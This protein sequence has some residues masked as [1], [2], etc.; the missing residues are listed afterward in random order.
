MRVLNVFTGHLFSRRDEKVRE[1]KVYNVVV[2]AYCKAKKPEPLL[3]I[4]LNVECEK[5]V[6][7]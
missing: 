7:L 1:G 5:G 4:R 2:V 6:D 3:H